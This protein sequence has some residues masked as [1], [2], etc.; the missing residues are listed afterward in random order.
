MEHHEGRI[1][2]IVYRGS[3][4]LVMFSLAR[5]GV[6]TPACDGVRTQYGYAIGST[7][8]LWNM[9]DGVL[10]LHSRVYTTK[11]D[12]HAG[13]ARLGRTSAHDPK[14]ETRIITGELFIP[15]ADTW[16]GI[17]VKDV[18]WDEES[19]RICV[20]TEFTSSYE[21]YPI[22]LVIDLI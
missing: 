22:F 3:I 16:E 11:P 5:S 17:K 4:N 19:G 2:T 18:N 12:E 8:M 6:G 21:A 20:V 9:Y 13:Y 15:G 7:R 10:A 1:S 14:D